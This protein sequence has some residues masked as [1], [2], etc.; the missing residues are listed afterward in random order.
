MFVC[1]WTGEEN[2]EKYVDRTFIFEIEQSIKLDQ[3]LKTPVY[4]RFAL[5]FCYI[6]LFYV[7]LCV[8]IFE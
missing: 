1:M 4:D 5:Q 8:K 7:C 6:D 2:V 3:W